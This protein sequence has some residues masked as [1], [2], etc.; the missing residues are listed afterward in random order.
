MQDDAKDEVREGLPANM[1]EPVMLQLKDMS[2]EEAQKLPL[3][4]CSDYT[5][6]SASVESLLG[7]P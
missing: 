2:T 4:H 7:T 3:L 6:G 1:V 5:N